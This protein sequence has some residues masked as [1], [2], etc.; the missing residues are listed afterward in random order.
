MAG[1]QNISTQVQVQ[2][3]AEIGMAADIDTNRERT[4][5]ARFS[6]LPGVFGNAQLGPVYLGP[7]HKGGVQPSLEPMA[8]WLHS[9]TAT[10]AGN[11]FPSDI[12]NA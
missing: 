10:V 4:S 2:G 12:P 7:V 9:T 5:N 6:S 8:R 1:Y 11:T 3:P